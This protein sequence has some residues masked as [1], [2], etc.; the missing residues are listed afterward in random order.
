MDN[1]GP[2]L[3]EKDFCHQDSK[4]SRFTSESAC[5]VCD[6]IHMRDGGCKTGKAELPSASHNAAVFRPRPRQHHGQCE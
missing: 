6:E 2:T 1:L 5:D 4:I 3:V